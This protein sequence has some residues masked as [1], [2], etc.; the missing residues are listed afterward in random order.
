MM[1]LKDH[2]LRSV[3]SERG[4]IQF[5]P[6]ILGAAATVGSAAIGAASQERANQ[7]QTHAAQ[8]QMEFQERMSNTAHQR[9]VADLRAAGLNPV[10]SAKY[11]GSSTPQGAMPVIQNPMNSA[12]SVGRALAEIALLKE[13]TKQVA[14]QAKVTANEAAVSDVDKEIDTSKFGRVMKYI[15]RLTGPLQTAFSGV[16]AA[17]GLPILPISSER[18]QVIKLRQ[19]KGGER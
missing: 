14:A 15:Q 13:Q 10:L 18:G 4:W 11:G 19:L 17:K 6:A 5:L 9:E 8:E 3:R 2:F 12:V 16:S 1:Y 7:E